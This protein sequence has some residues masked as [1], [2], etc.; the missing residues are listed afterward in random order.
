MAGDNFDD[1]FKAHI[2][3]SLE[4]VLADSGVAFLEIELTGRCKNQCT[5]CGV[6]APE[7]V[8]LSIGLLL[9]FIERWVALAHDKGLEPVISLTGGDP[10]L[11]PHFKALLSKLSSL[12]VVYLVKTNAHSINSSIGQWSY[13]PSAIKLT[14]PDSNNDGR[15]RENLGVLYSSTSYLQGLGI[16]VA[17]QASVH[18][19][20]M[21]ELLQII[22]ETNVSQPLTLVVGRILPL[23]YASAGYNVT[24]DKYYWFLK[25][26]LHIYSS[27]YTRGVELRFKDGLWIPLLDE[28][29]LLPK[30]YISNQSQSCDCFQSQ[31]AIDRYSNV[32]PCGLVRKTVLG[33][34]T[35]MPAQ[36]LEAR[37]VV[38]HSCRFQCYQCHYFNYC[39]GCVG[40]SEAIT[41]VK[42]SIDP[43]CLF[44]QR[45]EGK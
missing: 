36:L 41:N 35:E 1:N 13:K 15:H 45:L 16:H 5:Y 21:E 10:L 25:E 12:S 30:L 19:G 38:M 6:G 43:H 37:N 3:N 2:Q 23:G 22:G 4:V 7:D 11:Y 8:S 32:Y 33:Q 31:L 26:L 18:D 27:I 34:I 28:L 20:N 44:W 9:P 40:A 14:I 42:T 39:G 29:G 17:W 24:P